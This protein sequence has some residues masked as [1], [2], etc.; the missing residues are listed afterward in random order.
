LPSAVIDRGSV[1]AWQAEGGLDTFARTKARVA[2]LLATY[3]RPPMPVE[4]EREFRQMVA[5][6]A[7]ETGMD[8]L[9]DLE[10]V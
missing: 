2:E 1:R 3:Q 9:P 8:K 4:Q 6:V 10:E 5:R 7:S